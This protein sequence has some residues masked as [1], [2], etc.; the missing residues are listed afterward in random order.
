[1]RACGAI[2]SPRPRAYLERDHARADDYYLAE[3]VGLADRIVFNRD[4]AGAVST[5]FDSLDGERYEAWVDWKDPITGEVRGNVRTRTVTDPV[6]GEQIATATSPRFAE[7][8]VNADKTLSIAAAV[9]PRVSDALEVAMRDAAAAMG[10]YLAEHSVTRIGPLGAQR[11]VDVA[12]FEAA[13]VMHQTSRAGDPHRHAHVQ[14]STRVFADGKW[15]AL[16]TATTLRQQG[17]LRGIGEAVINAHT[18]LRAALADAGFT[19]DA[20]T[21]RV[22]ELEKYSAG[23]SKRATQISR[24]RDQLEAEWRAEHPGSTPGPAVVRS[25]DRLAWNLDR[26]D[27][28]PTELSTTARWMSDLEDAGYRA[29]KGPKVDVAARSIAT[30]DRHAIAAAAVVKA[31]EM[32]S[33]WSVADL[34][35]QVGHLVAA[36]G[37]VGDSAAL[38]ELIDDVTARALEQSISLTDPEV[39]RIPESLRYLTSARVLDVDAEISARLATRVLTPAADAELPAALDVDGRTVD[40]AQRDAV[41]MMAGTHGLVVFEGAAGAG[42][43]TALK[44]AKRE[45]AAQGRTQLIVAP[46]LKAAQEAGRATESDSSSLDKL[47]HEYGWRQKEGIRYRLQVGDVDERGY[48]YRGVPE[49]FAMD[50]R[51]QVVVDEA[52]MVDQEA[53]MALLTILDETGASLVLAGDRAQKGAVGRGGFFDQAAQRAEAYVD[54]TAVRR[55][56]TAEN[57]SDEDYA[58]LTLAMRSGNEP[59]RVFDSLVSRGLVHVHGTVEQARAAIAADA[60]ASITEGRSVSLT[61]ATNDEATAIN[62]V[63][64]QHL[65]AAG[66]V[67]DGQTVTGMDGSH[68]GRGDRIMTRRNDRDLE[69]ANRDV[70]TVTKVHRDGRLTVAGEDRRRRTL[71]AEYVAEHVHLAYAVT[72]FGNQGAT[73]DTAALLLT[74][75]TNSDGQYVGLTRGRYGNHV[76]V[77]GVDLTDARE[78]WTKAADRDS[79]D[80]GVEGAREKLAGQLRGLDLTPAADAAAAEETM[81]ADLTPEDAELIACEVARRARR[82]ADVDQEQQTRQRRAEWVAAGN[83]TPE[84][85]AAAAAAAAADVARA[86]AAH[87]AAQATTDAQAA[88]AAAAAATAAREAA[89]G[90]AAAAR[91][92]DAA[93]PLGRGKARAALEQARAAAAQQYGRPLPEDH[94]QLWNA[95]RDGSASWV[96]QVA[97]AARARR[98]AQAAET[99][100]PTAAA[101]AAARGI[102]QAAQE[103]HHA[104]LAEYRAQI[105]GGT[106]RGRDSVSRLSDEQLQQRRAQLAAAA[107]WFRTASV[108]QQLE[109]ARK[110]RGREDALARERAQQRQLAATQRPTPADQ[111]RAPSRGI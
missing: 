36:S 88:Q 22:V 13:V 58:A 57:T 108:A 90:I 86:E 94:A 72:D 24:N 35:D 23:M 20:Q 80:R 7:M 44:A 45:L 26:P 11:L 101:A 47:L 38:A 56:L 61:A 85:A 40:G 50:R 18:Q 111:D 89:A 34:T 41:A 10:R 3:G 73:T 105:G 28:K 42:K 8:V 39:G 63:T 4:A 99:L 92:V 93:G 104:L 64:R 65:V 43:T 62:D 67:D 75:A 19:F 1:M 51:T 37:V 33:A 70:F 54:V 78:Q 91:A 29:P 5:A 87:Q 9:D 30:L 55:F 48:E 106:S 59:G 15:R 52:G 82:L 74:D 102:Q 76:H 84:E 25:W 79:S 12:Q 27:K 97:G 68:V 49:R 66:V 31:A 46:T 81:R 96:D 6:T 14:F 77:I 110:Q 32:R 53:G 16:D 98:I 71:S 69:V 60:A 83:P 95:G 21:G 109:S 103:R 17:A 100:Q 2:A 107:D